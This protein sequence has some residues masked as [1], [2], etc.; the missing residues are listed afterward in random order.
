M[1]EN[2]EPCY[3]MLAARIESIRETLGVTQAELA[4]R[5][6]LSRPSI[7][8]IEVGRQRISLHHVERIAQGL[9]TTPKHLMRGVWF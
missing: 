1:T 4:K 8:N 5:T 3:R 9:G 7:A 2:I 6:G